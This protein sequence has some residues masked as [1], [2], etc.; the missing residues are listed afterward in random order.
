[1]PGPAP[2]FRIDYTAE[3]N[4]AQPRG[5]YHA[6]PP[7]VGDRRRR[8]QEDMLV[9][10]VAGGTFHSFANLVLRRA[11]RGQAPERAH[12]FANRLLR[13]ALVES[14]RG[15]VRTRDCYLAA[16]YRRL[17]KRR[18]DQKAILAVAPA[19]WS[20]PLTS[21]ATALNATSSTRRC[22]RRARFSTAMRLYWPKEEAE[23]E[24]EA[25]PLQRANTDLAAPVPDSA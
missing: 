17:V 8:Q 18:G 19:S 1:M 23:Q 3:L 5:R 24:M 16:Q 4:A 13:R 25:P 11:G 12:R 21:C 20:S 14:V 10:R 2:R 6:R 7:G 15:A 9:Y 22:C